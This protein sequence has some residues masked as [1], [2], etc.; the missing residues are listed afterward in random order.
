MLSR[1]PESLTGCV[2]P[3][4]DNSV[5]WTTEENL[6]RYGAKPLRW[7]QL[8]TRRCKTGFPRG[9]SQLT[10]AAEGAQYE[11]VRFPNSAIANISSRCRLGTNETCEE[12]L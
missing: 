7:L 3:V 1:K 11:A 4:K 12:R 5:L 8:G 9:F 6:D 10:F 2:H